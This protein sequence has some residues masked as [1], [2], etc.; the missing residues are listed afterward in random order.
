MS[1]QSIGLGRDGKFPT[2]LIVPSISLRDLVNRRREQAMYDE[3]EEQ[4]LVLT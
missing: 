3:T 1:Y 4:H 2:N